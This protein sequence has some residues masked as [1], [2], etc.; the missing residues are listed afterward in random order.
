MT[1]DLAPM[2]RTARLAMTRAAMA[3]AAVDAL[4][5]T[6]PVNIRWLTGF[7][8]SS[9][10]VVVG[11]EVLTLITDDRYDV[12]VR[13]QVADAAVE[14][15][16]AITRN[17]MDPVT[18]AVAGLPA[19]GLESDHITWSQQ[20]RIAGLLDAATTVPTEGLVET[21]RQVKDPGEIE[22]LKKA[23]AIADD[24]LA[25][26]RP[27]L[28]RGRTEVA[29]ARLLEREMIDRGADGLSFPTIVA[30][31][32]NSAKPH[33]TPSDRPIED[34]DMVVIDFGAAVDGYGSDMTRSFLVGRVS[35]RQQDMFDA[36]IEAQAA[37]V[38][39]VAAGVDEREIDRICRDRLAE[40][41]LAEAFTHG[42]GH[43]IGLEI[44]ENPFLST[45]ATGILRSGYVITVEPGVYL[46]ELGG[47]RI[48]DSVVVT[49]SG[50]EPITKS[51]KDP[52]IVPG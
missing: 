49:R 41:Q 33:A 40:H 15:T 32:L 9:G 12:Q 35:T 39:A 45:R 17:P 30:A 34:G 24:A 29:I 21:L 23:A 5:V 19:V 28:G 20:R 10:L 16:I 25:A 48:E 1:G 47:V 46:P 36:V 14:A 38:A 11:P 44:H 27:E 3:E 42:A 22:R 18:A 6:K 26:V 50:C 37:G 8:G 43:G 51:S 13:Q 7:T 4:V 52:T 2:D 31:G